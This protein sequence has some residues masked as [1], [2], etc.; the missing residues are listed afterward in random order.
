MAQVSLGHLWSTRQ[1]RRLL[2]LIDHLPATS[3]KDE[4]IAQ[5]DELI[6]ALVE[7][8]Q[9]PKPSDSGPPLHAFTQEVS[10]LMK[11]IDILRANNTLLI[12]INSKQGAHVAP[13][14]AELRPT[15]AYDRVQRSVSMDK[16]KRLVGKLLGENRG[17]PPPENA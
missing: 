8:N 17:G 13:P 5:D 14:E 7:N 3:R 1:W 2:N 4:A 6:R 15:T 9:M 16:Y 10:M 11:I 12:K